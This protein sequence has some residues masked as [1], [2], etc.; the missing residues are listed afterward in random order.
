MQ[1]KS[2]CGK[3]VTTAYAVSELLYGVIRSQKSVGS[4]IYFFCNQ[5]VND[6]DRTAIESVLRSLLFQLWTATKDDARMH[7][8]W[9]EAKE[10]PELSI[11]KDKWKFWSRLLGRILENVSGVTYIFIDAIEECDTPD[12]LISELINLAT[13]HIDLRIFIS[14]RDG[15]TGPI[16]AEQLV[17]SHTMDITHEIIES[18]MRLYIR[19]TLGNAPLLNNLSFKLTSTFKEE[20]EDILIGNANGM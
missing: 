4:V 12:K 11:E 18:D 9:N 20:I 14:S 6:P 17:G 3:T 19:Q 7:N 5:T 2:G 16:I 1:G 10:G 8:I 13:T 15:S